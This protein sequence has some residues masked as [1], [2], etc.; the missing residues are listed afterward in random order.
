[1]RQTFLQINLNQGC[2]VHFQSD[3]AKKPTCRTVSGAPEQSDGGKL[4]VKG[5]GV[6][7]GW[8]WGPEKSWFSECPES[9]SQ[10]IRRSRVKSKGIG[11]KYED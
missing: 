6:G 7:V 8:V 4:S 5:T 10:A 3:T 11:Y 2:A 9:E 1:M